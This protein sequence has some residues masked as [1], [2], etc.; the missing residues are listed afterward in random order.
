[1]KTL[2]AIILSATIIMPFAAHAEMNDT[3]YCNALS[4]SYRKV[5]GSSSST[6]GGVPEAM[7]GCA[8][9]PKSSI[10]T[11]EK[12]LTDQKATLPKR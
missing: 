10:P 2:T 11:L 6:A 4:A 3:E 1:M 7:A 9:T 12:A 5:V 8:T